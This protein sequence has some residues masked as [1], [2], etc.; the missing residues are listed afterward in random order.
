MPYDL[1]A[2]A[3]RAGENR[4]T[5][6]LRAIFPTKALA[7]DLARIYMRLVRAWRD[8]AQELILPAYSRALAELTNDSFTRDDIPDIEA[9]IARAEAQANAVI[10]SL[11]ISID[12][13]A[14]QTQKWHADKFAANVAAGTSIDVELLMSSETMRDTLRAFIAENT[15]L[16]SSI[17]EKTRTSIA[18]IVWRGYLARTPRREIAREINKAIGMARDRA[19]RIASD[20]TVKLAAKLDELRQVEAGIDVFEWRHS[21]KVHFRPE[22]KARNG[23]RFKW[24]SAVART[25]P[26]GRAINCACKS[27]PVLQLKKDAP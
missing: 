8:A 24:T 26:P 1:A 12:A 7:Q 5:I 11:T 6:T 10:A 2:M 22:H 21:G 16:I 20:Q 23:K 25:D 3:K 27:L 19:L 13:W 18:G 9:E 4:S 17:S 15:N 14:Q